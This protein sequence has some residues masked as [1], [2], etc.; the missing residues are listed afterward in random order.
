ML[1]SCTRAPRH[2]LKGAFAV[3]WTL[4]FAVPILVC[5][6]WGPSIRAQQGPQ[7]YSV[8]P[9]VQFNGQVLGLIDGIFGQPGAQYIQGWACEPENPNPLQVQMYTDG[10]RGVGQLYRTYVANA[11]PGNPGVSSACGTTTGH[12]FFIKISGDIFSRAAQSIY[13]NAIASSGQYQLDGS[14][15]YSTPT[16]TTL[17]RLEGID[18]NGFAS[19]W[20]FDHLNTSASIDVAVYADGVSL[21][22]AE[23]G[24]L[25]WKGPANQPSPGLDKAYG[26]TGDHGFSV[27]LPSWVTDGVH[28]LSFYAVNVGNKVDAPL[29][30][31]PAVPGATKLAT[32][33]S[34]ATSAQGFPSKWRGYDLPAGP[35]NLVGLSGTV[36]LHNSANIYS[37]ILFLV[38]YKPSESCPTAGTKSEPM[39]PIVW[40]DIIKA[41][42]AGVFSAPVSFTLPV[43]IPISH[44][45]VIGLGGGTVAAS[46]EVTGT[47]NLVATYTHNPV[48][49]TQILWMDSEFCFG[50]NWGC[51]L[52]TTDDTQSFAA[53]TQITQRSS[54]NAI[55]GNISDSTFDGS[56]SFGPPPTGPWIATNDVYIYPASDCS[57]FPAGRSLNGPGDYYRQVPPDATHLLAVPLSGSGGVGEGETINYLLPGWT[58]GIAVYETFSDVTLNSGE[59]FV[60]LYGL[61]HTTGA[62]DNEDQIHAIVTPF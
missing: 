25:V 37:E 54:L 2:L 1:R 52:A 29:A 19:G 57:Q 61:Q 11:S 55:S 62:F 24:R 47:L 10:G 58:N 27:Q 40:S 34:F 42:T 49:S 28:S 41:P 16:P 9:L 14:G 44:C 56:S 22:G 21:L 30:E 59:C 15:Q 51:E 32:H 5:L 6:S 43:G 13:I 12:R 53:V 36:T 7:S 4:V 45:L 33:I 20:A 38:S 8:P 50:Q 35:L 18:A 48:D 26:I 60:L 3:K 17:G 46:H 23:T 39:G 31:S